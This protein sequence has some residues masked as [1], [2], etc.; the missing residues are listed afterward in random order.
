MK[1]KGVEGFPVKMLMGG[2]GR[3]REMVMEM[4]LGEH[5]VN[6]LV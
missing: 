4:K 1:S 3:N 6:K 5:M 2:R